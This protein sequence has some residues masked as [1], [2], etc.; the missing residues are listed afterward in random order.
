MAEKISKIARIATKISK[1]V[2]IA[3]PNRDYFEALMNQRRVKTASSEEV[4]AAAK[5]GNEKVNTLFDEVKALNRKVN[6]V[7]TESSPRNLVAQAEDAVGQIE[8]IKDKLETP[9]LNLKSSIK[10]VLK[11]RLS[12]IDDNL[13][14]ALE[15]AGL[16]YRPPEKTTSLNKPMDRFLG[17][18]THAQNGL[19]TLAMDIKQRASKSLGGLTP[20]DTFVIQI[21]MAQISQQIELFTSML[22]KALESTKTIMN[23]QV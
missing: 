13:K 1:Q 6:A 7:T 4:A 18:L 14:I 12:H 15:K 9:N 5:Q 3:E 20:A 11:N 17:L 22:N 21:K 16:E 8:V 23:V 10:T 19:G 2:P